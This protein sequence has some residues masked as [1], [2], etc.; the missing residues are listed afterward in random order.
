MQ[1]FGGKGEKSGRS[2]RTKSK[3]K[4]KRQRGEASKGS[5][6]T[7]QKKKIPVR[8]LS[9]EKKQRSDIKMQ[10]YFLYQTFDPLHT[11]E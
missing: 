5:K 9:S 2:N 3:R 1:T 6:N 11:Q 7:R 10:A 8:L 4:K